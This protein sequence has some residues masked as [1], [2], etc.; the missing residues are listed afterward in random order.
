MNRGENKKKS[1][2]GENKKKSATRQLYEKIV[3]VENQLE[4]LREST[5]QDSD[6]ALGMVT[7]LN[8]EVGQMQ[9]D[10]QQLRHRLELQEAGTPKPSTED[11]F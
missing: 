4:V 10:I 3:A 7:D 6:V 9:E 1:A 8:F 5:K 2:R 11:S